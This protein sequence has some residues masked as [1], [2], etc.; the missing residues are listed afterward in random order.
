[1][2]VCSLICLY[3]VDG[4]T[5]ARESTGAQLATEKLRSWAFYLD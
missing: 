1:M 4:L 5:C 3:L 2:Y